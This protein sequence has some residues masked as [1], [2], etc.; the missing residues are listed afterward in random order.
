VA[1]LLAFNLLLVFLP[2]A[3]FVLFGPYERQLLESQERAMVQ[4]GRLA[5]SALAAGGEVS[6]ATARTLLAELGRRSDSRLRVV[7]REG[8]LLADSSVLGPRRKGE[9]PARAESSAGARESPLYWL[10]A[11]PFELLG[12]LTEPPALDEAEPGEY[13][14]TAQ[15]LDGPEIRAALAGRYGAATRFSPAPE[16]AVILYSAIPIRV[17]GEVAGAVLVSQSTVR[18]LAELYEVRLR[19]FEV[20]LASVLGAVLLSVFLAGTIA[21]PL[22]ALAAEARALVDGRGRL[23]GRFRGSA[24]ADEIG[25]L[26]RSLEELTRRLEARQTATEAFA[27]DLSHE[28]KNPLASIRAATEM[29]AVAEEPAERRRFLAVV[30][31]EVARMERLLASVREIVHLDAPEAGAAGLAVD[32]GA[33]AEQLVEAFRLRGVDGVQFVLERPPEP[34]LVHGAPERFAALLENLLDNAAGFSPAGGKVELAIERSGPT[35]R[36]R[37]SDRG[38][39]LPDEHV[40]RVFDRFFTWRPDG[41]RV[42]GDHAGLG[43]AIVRAVAEA[44]GGRVEAGNRPGGGAV[45]TVSLPS[46]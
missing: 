32:L 41:A 28:F 7:D 34:V 20:F 33:L 17:G 14:A 10:G 44:H 45:F 9:P 12:R 31:Q 40:E 30:E 4:Q 39:G 38:P 25:E 16:R 27:A 29:L 5:A 13:Y 19:L 23:R 18:I 11:L 35:V 3:G 1:R 21:R 15:R 46:A 43:L 22:R 26:A 24:R 8:R 6:T 36:V 42:R 2:V 37:V